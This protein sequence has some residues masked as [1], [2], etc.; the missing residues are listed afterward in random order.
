MEHRK[1]LLFAAF[2]TLIAAGVGFAVRTQVVGEWERIFHF[3]KTEMGEILGMGFAGFGAVIILSSFITDRVGY[4]PLLVAAF[5]MH[6]VSFVGTVLATGVYADHGQEATVQLL[7]WSTFLF[8]V[9]NGCCE[10]VINPLV[11]TLYPE[12]KTHYLNILHAGW[13]GGMIIGG[14]LTWCFVGD[15]A[16]VTQMRWE[17]PMAFFIV[18]TLAYGWLVLREKFPISEA[19]AA[20][21]SYGRMLAA[22]ASPVLLCL[23]VLHACIGYVELGTDSWI[24]NIMDNAFSGKGI[25]LFV[26]TAGLMFV[27]RFFAGPIVDRINPLGLLLVSSLFACLGLFALGSATAGILIFGAATL[28]GIG[29]SFLWP[30]MLGVVGERFPHGGAL[31][32]GM[33]GGVGMLSAGLLGGPGIGY[34]QDVQASTYLE[35]ASPEAYERVKVDN[36][37]S[38]LFFEEVYGLDDAR[39]EALP[40]GDPDIPLVTAAALEGGRSSLRITSIVPAVMAIGYLLLLLVFRSRGGYRAIQLAGA[41]NEEGSGA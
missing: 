13:P 12:R 32:M 36:P 38:F 22:F 11:A 33:I 7:K 19:R 35:A 14:V 39:I 6:L 40:E 5:V 2:M 34:T 41:A 37:R 30:T 18:P 24:T 31:T 3:S 28:Y 16:V 1:R 8:A 4:K 21:V 26:Y 29:K 27:L 10:A 9:A 20:G 17:I 25:L 23:L 15:G